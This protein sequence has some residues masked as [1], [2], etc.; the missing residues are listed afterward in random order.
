MLAPAA[1]SRREMAGLVLLV[2]FAAA[3]HSAT[4]AVLMA[5]VAAAG[6]ARLYRRDLLPLP[7]LGR[8]AGALDA[9]RHQFPLSG[10]LATPGGSQ[11]GVGRRARTF[12]P[13]YFRPLH[14]R[15]CCRWHRAAGILR[16]WA[17]GSA[18][19]GEWDG[20]DIKLHPGFDVRQ[21]V[22][23]YH[24]LCAYPPIF[25]FQQLG[26][27]DVPTCSIRERSDAASIYCAQ[28]GILWCHLCLPKLLAT[29]ILAGLIIYAA[30]A[31]P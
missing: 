19:G 10:Q 24:H 4:L 31:W 29:L 11:A 26:G 13:G 25:R 15:R 21:L 14:L 17:V 9:A 7:A 20:D 1:L 30:G 23:L 22:A 2:G 18:F 3:T 12:S 6:L 5:I 16:Y 8:G 27:G 28:S